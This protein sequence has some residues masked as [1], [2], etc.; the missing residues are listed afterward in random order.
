[1]VR[2]ARL[3]SADGVVARELFATMAAVFDDD[4]EPLADAYLDA[5]LGRDS[6]WALAAFDGAAVVGGLTAHTLPLTTSE[7]SEIF[8]YD[9]AVVPAQQRRGIGRTLV[10]TLRELAAAQG[11]EVSFVPADNDDVHAL[12]FYRALGGAAA[13]VTIFTFGADED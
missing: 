12:D 11:I 5:L 7:A 9:L 10:A 3:T 2:I 6:F 1:M 4:A 13:P 8:I